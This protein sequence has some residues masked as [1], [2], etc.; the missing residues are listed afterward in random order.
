MRRWCY[1]N[2]T[3]RH[4]Q[5][6][7]R[8]GPLVKPE[9]LFYEEALMYIN[10]IEH[11]GKEPSVVAAQMIGW[12]Y[13]SHCWFEEQN[14]PVKK[15]VWCGAESTEDMKIVGLPEPTMCL[16][17]PLVLGVDLREALIQL[18]VRSE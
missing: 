15:C 10:Q 8:I 16:R 9:A 5:I 18:G 3:V 17:N 13:E 2:G 12:L 11:K 7:S 6:S 4:W 1:P 14:N